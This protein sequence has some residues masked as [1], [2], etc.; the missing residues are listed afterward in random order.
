MTLFALGHVGSDEVHAGLNQA[1]DEVNIACQAIKLCDQE[2]G[3][4]LA[5]H[6]KRLAQLRAL[7]EGVCVLAGLDLVR[8]N[9]PGRWIPKPKFLTHG[10][11]HLVQVAT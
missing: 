3:P 9:Y 7:A 11:Q 10:R 2:R 1:A 8:V 4:R 5:T 6:L